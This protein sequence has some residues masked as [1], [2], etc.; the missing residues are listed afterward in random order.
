MRVEEKLKRE[1]PTSNG[2]IED[3]RGEEDGEADEEERREGLGRQLTRLVE[4]VLARLEVLWKKQKETLAVNLSSIRE[5][6]RSA[7]AAL[8]RYFCAFL[9]RSLVSNT[10]TRAAGVG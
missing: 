5:E 3:G 4:L 10:I 6:E 9:E 1:R 7:V 2:D 8:G